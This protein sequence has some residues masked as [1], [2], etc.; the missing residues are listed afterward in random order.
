MLHTEEAKLTSVLAMLF[1]GL[2]AFIGALMIFE[3]SPDADVSGSVGLTWGGLAMVFAGKAIRKN[4]VVVKNPRWFL[5]A[6][7]FGISSSAG[8]YRSISMSDIA[9]V[10]GLIP[11]QVFA[12]YALWRSCWR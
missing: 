5:A 1:G 11:M 12:L 2:L 7:L 6:F 9:A 3:L 8:L 10:V 4:R